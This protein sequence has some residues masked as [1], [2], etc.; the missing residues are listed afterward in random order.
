[1][2]F[3][4]HIKSLNRHAV[5]LNPTAIGTIALDRV[6]SELKL[7]NMS[8]DIL[9]DTIE[10]LYTDVTMELDEDHARITGHFRTD[11]NVTVVVPTGFINDFVDTN[12]IA[13]RD[14]KTDAITRVELIRTVDTEHILA[15]WSDAGYPLKWGI[16]T[17]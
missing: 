10:S 8:A 4:I 15:T 16:E 7:Q 13:I 5:D 6:R 17:E 14:I 1:M 12:V 11:H 3:S 9:C 2:R